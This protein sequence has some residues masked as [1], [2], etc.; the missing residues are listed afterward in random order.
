MKDGTPLPGPLFPETTPFRT[1]QL[2]VGDGHSLYVEECGRADGAPLV[3]LHGGPGSGCSPAHRRFFDPSRFRAVLFDQRGCGRSTPLAGLHDN[4]TAHLVADIE[5]IR[6]ALGIQRWIVFGGSWGSLLALAYALS[7]PERIAG[8]V[9]RGI[10]LGSDDELRRYTQGLDHAAPLA[11][12]TFAAGV[13]QVERGDLL[14]AYTTRLLGGDLTAMRQW[15]DY[16]RAL[17]GEPPLA[18]APTAQQRAKALIQAHYLSHHCFSDAFALLA[19]CAGLRHLPIAI[20]QG[21]RDPVCPARA[22]ERLHRALPHAEW[23]AVEA[24]R[25]N[26]FAA[27]MAAACMAAI[28][29]IAKYANN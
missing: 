6:E 19:G 9:L 26:A 27:D 14:N 12:Q 17:M 13:P 29:R 4:T 11:W 28:D 22:A 2:P 3:F 16:E 20:V 18:Q 24:G 1:R 5:R 15:L 10:F 21:S 25:H 23:I 7:A 8:L